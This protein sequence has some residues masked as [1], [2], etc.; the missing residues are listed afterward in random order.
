MRRELYESLEKHNLRDLKVSQLTPEEDISFLGLNIA[1]KREGPL[2][3]IALDQVG[4]L[5]SLL[6]IYEE[7]LSAITRNPPTPCGDDAFRPTDEGTDLEPVNTTQFLSKLM[8]TR[9][10]VRTRPDIE[11]A[12][13]ILTT[14]SRSPTKGDNKRLNRVLCY[15]RGTRELGIRLHRVAN[16]KIHAYV[17]AAYAVHPKMESHTGYIVTLDKF[18]PPLQ[19][20]SIKQKLNVN[21]STEAEL[22]GMHEMLDF[23]LW[24]RSIF[25]FLG[26]EQGTTTLYQDNTST[27]TMAHMG[28]GSSGSNTRHIQIKYFWI[29][30][31]IDS[32]VIKLEHLF[33]DNMIADFF[34]SPRVGQLFRKFRDIVMGRAV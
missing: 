32:K 22:V 26:Y 34:A 28:R 27:I 14:K 2:S 24:L 12:I 5:D 23:V 9:Y 30:Q 17:D 18:G 15:L 19:Y 31:F 7:E 4:Y 8:R 11:L 20:K 21:S 29:K 33:T 6:S 1:L 10:L 3:Y 16:I 13:S 25:S